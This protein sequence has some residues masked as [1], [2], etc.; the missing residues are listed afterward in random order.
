M[1]K[2]VEGKY[3]TIWAKGRYVQ[4]KVQTGQKK[5]VLRE[6][7]DCTTVHE[8]GIWINKKC[9]HHVKKQMGWKSPPLSKGSLSDNAV[10]SNEYTLTLVMITH[11]FALIHLQFVMCLL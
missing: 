10:P 3:W 11:K 4:S 1:P 8:N 6:A 2:S 7:Q 9:R 5:F